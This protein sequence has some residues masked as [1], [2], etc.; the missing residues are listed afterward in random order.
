MHC[1]ACDAML[2]EYETKRKHKVTGEYLDLC[3]KCLSSVQE[4]VKIDYTGEQIE[5]E[6]HNERDEDKEF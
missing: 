1:L 2:T 5:E 3:S 6:Q 4:V